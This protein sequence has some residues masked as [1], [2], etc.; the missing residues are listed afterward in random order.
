MADIAAYLQSLPSPPDNGVGPGS[1]L[2][3]GRSLYENHCV[4][5]HQERGEGERERFFPRV[6]NQHYNYLL[7]QMIQIRDGVRRNAN[8][9][10]V[11]V[12]KPYSDQDL[13][14]VADYMSRLGKEPSR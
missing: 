5:C 10:M 13:E 8:P 4:K 9:K 7:R 14:A 6:A 2:D 11:K 12:V 3:R 1:A